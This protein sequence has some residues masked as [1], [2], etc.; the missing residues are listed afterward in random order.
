MNITDHDLWRLVNTPCQPT[1]WT[2]TAHHTRTRTTY[3]V[4]AATRRAAAALASEYHTRFTL[5]STNRRPLISHVTP[6][7]PNP[8]H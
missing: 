7:Q 8:L 5:T 3:H 4:N 6:H 1:C 2:V